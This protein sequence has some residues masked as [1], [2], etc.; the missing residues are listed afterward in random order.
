MMAAAA[1]TPT[2]RR[3]YRGKAVRV[4]ERIAAAVAEGRFPADLPL[5]DEPTL[6]RLYGIDRLTLRR[7]LGLLQQQGLLP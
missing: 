2:Q 5:P 6:Y 4:A 3:P 1:A 7:A